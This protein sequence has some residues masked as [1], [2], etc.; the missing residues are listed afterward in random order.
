MVDAEDDVDDMVGAV[1]C[2]DDSVDIVVEEGE[3]VGEGRATKMATSVPP[4]RSTTTTSIVTARPTP[5]RDR[6]WD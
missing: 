3:A 1:V 5:L 4:P 2:A 6:G